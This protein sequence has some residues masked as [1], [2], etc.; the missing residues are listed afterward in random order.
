M[1]PV[2]SEFR[3]RVKSK[4]LVEARFVKMGGSKETD[5]AVLFQGLWVGRCSEYPNKKKVIF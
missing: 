5:C 3:T 1:L 4:Q 2:T